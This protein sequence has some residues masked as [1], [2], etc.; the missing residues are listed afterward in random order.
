MDVTSFS[1]FFGLA[2]LV[3]FLTACEDIGSSSRVP[4]QAL[5]DQCA[6]NSIANRYVIRWKDGQITSATFDGEKQMRE[7]LSRFADDISV[8]END[9]KVH[10]HQEDQVQTTGMAPINWGQDA[11]EA[12]AAWNA[13]VQGSGVVVAVVDSGVDRTHAQISPRLAYNSKEI[14]NNGIDD[15]GNGLVD[16]VSGYWF[17]TEYTEDGTVSHDTANVV[18]TTGHGTHVAGIIAADHSSGSIEG[19]APQAKIL[20]INFMDQSGSGGGSMSDATR[21]IAYA[22]SQGAKVINASWG[23]AGC[24]TVLKQEISELEQ[25]GV[26]FVDAS[27][28]MGQDIDYTPE[29]PAGFGLPGQIVVGAFGPAGMQSQ[30]SNYSTKLVHLLA[31]GEDIISTYPSNILCRYTNSYSSTCK[32]SGTSMASPFVAGTVALLMGDRPQATV[33]QIKQAIMSSVTVGNFDVVTHGKLNVKN[34]L[35]ALR[36]LVP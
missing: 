7:V 33:A 6:A 4:Y 8:V 20:P 30:F 21:A 22:V 12:P 3:L 1:K 23:G 5:K 14:P 27:G 9:Q 35:V 28:N 11:V 36:A 17:L 29:Y 32:L 19:V 10:L 25:Q 15:D 26:V 18:D 24:S 16:D 34:A 31:P 2:F 13:N